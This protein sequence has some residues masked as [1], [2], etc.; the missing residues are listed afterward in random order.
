MKFFLSTIGADSA[1]AARKHGL[2][3]EIAEFCTASNMEEGFPQ[4]DARV[5]EE[6]EGVPGRIFHAPF[7]ELFPCAVDPRARELAS[8]R[9]RQA[10]RLAKAYGVEKVVIHGGFQPFLY[11]P[12]WYVEQSI[13]FWKNFLKE[14]PGVEI[15]LENVLEPEPE[16][17]RDLAAG[18][19]HPGFR[20][21]L[22]VGHV[23]AY[24]KGGIMAWM[25]Y[26]RPWLSHFHLHN[27]DGTGDTHSP[28]M[29]GTIPMKQLLTQ[30]RKDCPN[31]TCT[32]ELQETEPS[33]LW[34]KEQN[35]I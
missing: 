30:V 13:A 26:L 34:L 4:W 27:N 19:N 35:F 32:L 20:L 6:L 7:N 24:A 10:I 3:L 16:M 14:D 33:V 31:A 21:C 12:V 8:F 1:S 5:R 9:Y 28:L 15:V 29:T 17:L 18:V 2:G 25:E 22:D 23:N 11:Y